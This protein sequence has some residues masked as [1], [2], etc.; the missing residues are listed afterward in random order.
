MAALTDCIREQVAALIR[1]LYPP[2]EK[3]PKRPTFRGLQAM[4]RA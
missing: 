3:D 2:S 1:R 4:A